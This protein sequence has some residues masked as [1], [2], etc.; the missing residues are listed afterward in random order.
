MRIKSQRPQEGAG[1]SKVPDIATLFHSC[2][3][4]PVDFHNRHHL[5]LLNLGP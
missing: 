4:I 2:S 5:T 1:R 3:A